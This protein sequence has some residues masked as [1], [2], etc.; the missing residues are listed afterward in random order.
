M[1]KKPKI[2]PTH[3]GIYIFWRGKTALY[4]GKAANLRKRVSSYFKKN[5]AW[6]VA[7]LCRESTRIE[8]RKAESGIEALIKESGAIKT[9]RPKFNILMRDDKGY[10]YVALT[11]DK[12][13]RFY[14]THQP[15]NSL[16]PA[17]DKLPP[18]AVGP[19]VEAT[20]I[21]EVMRH[22]RTIFPF[23]SCKRLHHGVCVNA[24][25][26]R[27]P[28]YCCIKER[29]VTKADEE[30]YTKNIQSILSL[31][32]GKRNALIGELKKEIKKAS[33][34]E[35][36]EEAAKL[37][38]QIYGL[39]ALTRRRGIAVAKRAETPYHKIERVLQDILSTRSPVKR[40]EGYDIANISGDAATGSMVVFYEGRPDK[41]Q[42]RKFKIK[43][44][45]GP[46][47]VGSHREVVS[48]R[49]LHDEW[50]KPDLM[51]IDGGKAQLNAV[52]ALLNRKPLKEVRVAALS[53]PPRKY[54]TRAP[55]G[56]GHMEDMLYL[57]AKPAPIPLKRLPSVVA[58]F[59]QRVRDESHR[60]A[61]VYHHI[62]RRKYLA[63]PKS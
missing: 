61:R 60:F 5:A 47:D 57:P 21:K 40:I 6:K 37:R 54:F 11:D 30:S 13:P 62:L 14:F 19:F 38:N 46:N 59:L 20:L 49:L 39:E 52:R 55:A 10:L 17:T 12:F 1:L 45:L 3:P 22:L 16:Q 63:P 15:H 33:K 51:L 44:I 28:R 18:K 31:L 53:K 29:I 36:Y 25:I 43:T 23:C 24:Q 48:R 42:Y 56:A 7:E 41:S 58:H 27:C 2:I 26:G 32:S 8:F 35:R 34:E 4:V 9:Y 50:E